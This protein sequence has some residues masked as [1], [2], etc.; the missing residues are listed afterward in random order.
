MFLNHLHS[1]LSVQQT[2]KTIKYY[3]IKFKMKVQN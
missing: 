1:N 3:N 2:K